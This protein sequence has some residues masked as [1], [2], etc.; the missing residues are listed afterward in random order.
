[1]SPSLLDDLERE[2]DPTVLD[3]G[4]Q[5]L[6]MGPDDSERDDVESE[7]SEAGPA[8][9]LDHDLPVPG[10]RPSVAAMR[11]GLR[12]FDDVD[13]CET[14]TAGCSREEHS[15]VSQGFVSSCFEV[16]FGRDQYGVC[17]K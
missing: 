14:F 12:F 6:S 16:C 3:R 4:S 11:A 9:E 10:H 7:F 1:M 8:E 15:K 17:P 2:L 13:L 5:T